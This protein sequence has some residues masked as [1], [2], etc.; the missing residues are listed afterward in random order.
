VAIAM[1]LQLEGRPQSR[2]LSFCMHRVLANF[3]LRMR[4]NCYCRL[5]IKILT[6]P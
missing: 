3:V 2:Q 1:A 6:S 5:P 4:T